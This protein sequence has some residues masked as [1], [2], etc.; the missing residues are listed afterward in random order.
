M[1]MEQQSKPEKLH[2]F[3]LQDLQDIK[4]LI[5]GAP[6]QFNQARRAVELQDKIETMIKELSGEGK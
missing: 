3:N 2:L 1:Q 6:I 5:E 4:N